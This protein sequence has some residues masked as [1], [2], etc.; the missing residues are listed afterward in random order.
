VEERHKRMALI[1][2]DRRRLIDSDTWKDLKKGARM[3]TERVFV[4]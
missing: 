2:W 4:G 1:V 3:M